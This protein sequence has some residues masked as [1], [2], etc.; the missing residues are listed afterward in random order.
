ME[1]K[2]KQLTDPVI[3]GS[4]EKRAPGAITGA[5]SPLKLMSPEAWFGFFVDFCFVHFCFVQRFEDEVDSSLHDFRFSA[6]EED[7]RRG[8]FR[9]ADFLFNF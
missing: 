7:A 6:D 4:L 8:A 9:I 2:T 5:P 1:W 3:P